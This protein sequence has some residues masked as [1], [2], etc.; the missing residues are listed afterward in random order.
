[1]AGYSRRVFV[2]SFSTDDDDTFADD[3]LD[4]ASNGELYSEE[5]IEIVAPVD[6][7]ATASIASGTLRCEEDDLVMTLSSPQAY[8]SYEVINSADG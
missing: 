3:N 8:F 1:M 5:S 7:D 6:L 4:F 2:R